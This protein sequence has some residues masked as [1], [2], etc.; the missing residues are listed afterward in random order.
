MRQATK[1]VETFRFYNANVETLQFSNECVTSL[2]IL[3]GREG[4]PL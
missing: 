2:V 3:E 1:G 4:N